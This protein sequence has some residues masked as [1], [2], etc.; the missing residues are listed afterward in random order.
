M[1]M[2]LTR[3]TD[4][5]VRSLQVLADRAERVKGS[6]LAEMTGTTI[7]FLPQVISPLTRAGW[8]A[9]TAGSNGGYELVVPA[10]SISLLQVIEACEGPVS[11]GRCIL[12]PEP[13]PGEAACMVHETWEQART[14]LLEGLRAR[15][16]WG[17][18]GDP[19]RVRRPH[20]DLPGT[21][22]AS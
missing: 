8:V 6:E 15:S 3:S 10:D 2:E 20:N 12:R 1:R 11:E 4:L 9:S 18:N 13:C 14:V 7:S 17:T 16:I 21:G 22:Q 5:A 19:A